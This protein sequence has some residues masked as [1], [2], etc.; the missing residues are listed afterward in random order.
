MFTTSGATLTVTLS[1]TYMVDG[2]EIDLFNKTTND[3]NIGSSVVP[4]L[5]TTTSN[6]LP[7]MCGATVK[8]I[9]SIPGFSLVGGIV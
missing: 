2:A 9:A 1:T 6:I 4:I 5:S 7:S 8:Y 3:I